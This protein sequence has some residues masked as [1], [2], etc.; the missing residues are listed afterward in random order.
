MLS[1]RIRLDEIE[2]VIQKQQPELQ[3]LDQV[4]VQEKETN[5]YSY[6]QTYS[7]KTSY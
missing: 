5:S 6:K 2:Q 1:H 3:A 4:T 7:R